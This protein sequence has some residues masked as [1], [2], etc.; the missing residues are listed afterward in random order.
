[1]VVANNPD[2]VD[3]LFYLQERAS[4]PERAQTLENLVLSLIPTEGE[5]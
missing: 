5:L 2:L 1:V 3:S 4:K